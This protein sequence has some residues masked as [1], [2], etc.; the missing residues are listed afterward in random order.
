MVTIHRERGFSVVLYP[1]DR[2]HTPPHVH[3]FYGDE[4]VKIALG[5]DET[6]PW[7]WEVL[8]MRRPNVARA[9]TIVEGHQ[10]AFLAQWRKYHGA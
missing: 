2:E 8:E 10:E 5:D 3:V 9:L 7:I 6:A 1:G 4:E